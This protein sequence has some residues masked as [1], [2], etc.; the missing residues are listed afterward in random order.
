MNT[1]SNFQNHLPAETN[2]GGFSTSVDYSW[3]DTRFS[4]LLDRMNAMENT[5]NALEQIVSTA[6]PPSTQTAEREYY[7]VQEFATLVERSE[8]TVR[9]WCRYVRI[10]AEKCETGR[11]EAKS[12]KIPAEELSRYRDHGL[13]AVGYAG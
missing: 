1:P 13:L 3:F 9:E 7:S 5:I 11:G 8:Y 12:W 4:R 2:Q 10:N 6:D